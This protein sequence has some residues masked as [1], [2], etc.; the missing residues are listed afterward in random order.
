MRA[1]IKTP[2]KKSELMRELKAHQKADNFVRGR[3]FSFGKGCAVGC[4]LHSVAK[5]KGL[6]IGNND[7]A[8][9]SNHYEYEEYF[10]I[11]EFFAQL[12]DVLFETISEERSKTFPVEIIKAIKVGA[13]LK[14]VE[15]KFKIEIMKYNLK[16]IKDVRFATHAEVSDSDYRI[17][18]F[19]K[20]IKALKNNNENVMNDLLENDISA[21]GET[22]IAHAIRSAFFLADFNCKEAASDGLARAL[23]PLEV[24]ERRSK[25][26]EFADIFIK[27]VK[28][29]K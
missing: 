17:K 28:G 25:Y 5:I 1:F 10:N 19:K 12:S 15:N 29:C 14:D 6:T 27:L 22:P 2:I 8:K 7:D 4:S 9:F 3:Y 13:N 16:I 23:Y 24:N 18:T 26:E 20:F 11:P 21:V